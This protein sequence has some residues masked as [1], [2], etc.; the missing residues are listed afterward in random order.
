MCLSCS[1]FRKGS[2]G[3]SILDG[4]AC[5]TSNKHNIKEGNANSERG[6]SLCL[7]LSHQPGYLSQT[8]PSSGKPYHGLQGDFSVLIMG[9]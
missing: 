5:F 8:I 9:L 4:S 7:V 2:T 6:A 1:V 3:A